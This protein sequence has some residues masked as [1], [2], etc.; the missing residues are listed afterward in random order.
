MIAGAEGMDVVTRGAANIARH[1]YFGARKIV[2]CR[3]LHVGSIA[4]KGRNRQSR[5]LR[6]RGVVGEVVAAVLGGAAMRR[7]N[8]VE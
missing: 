1:L 5:P 8:G 7:Q 3:E 2:R 4:F 6:D